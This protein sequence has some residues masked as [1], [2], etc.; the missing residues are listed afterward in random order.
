MLLV[1]FLCLSFI[2]SSLKG[3]GYENFCQHRFLGYACDGILWHAA[4]PDFCLWACSLSTAE[5]LSV[6]KVKFCVRFCWAK[7][8]EV[9]F[10][11]II[12]GRT[13]SR[14]YVWWCVLFLFYVSVF[15]VSSL[16]GVGCE[17]FCQHR[18][19]GYACDGILWHAAQPDFCLWAC[20]LSTAECL[21]VWK[22]KF[23]VRF[24]WAKQWEVEFSWT[25]C[26]RT[27]SRHYVWWCFL[28]LFYVSVFIVSSF[29]GVG[30]ENFCQHRFL[31]YA[32]DGILWHAAQ[33]DFC[34]WACSLSTAEC[35]SVWNHISSQGFAGNDVKR[36]E[37][38][39]RG[40][41]G[42]M[43]FCICLAAWFLLKPEIAV[44][45]TLI[46]IDCSNMF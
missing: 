36:T 2:V 6:W 18:F 7:Q 42:N 46:V 30:C 15:I 38:G 10:S 26:G 12:C 25:I 8:W 28:F 24:C 22:V 41:L 32:C 11:W 17:N 34:L 5:C 21:S 27:Q 1:P 14:H 13:Q 20:S 31:G 4:Q 29:K 40:I 43:L 9:E 45:V 37:K 3:V 44:A 16:K 33:P 35:L 39:D 23:C 19:L